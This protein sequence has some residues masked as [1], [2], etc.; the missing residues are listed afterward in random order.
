[1]DTTTLFTW[2]NY[3]AVQLNA[4]NKVRLTQRDLVRHVE[5]ELHLERFY[6]PDYPLR[7]IHY[8]FTTFIRAAV[9]AFPGR[10]SLSTASFIETMAAMA[11]MDPTLA[12]VQKEIVSHFFKCDIRSYQAYFPGQDPHYRV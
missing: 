3:C 11:S 9:S 5:L 4:E 2:L 10:R 6:Q 12:K 8:V 1:M 7:C